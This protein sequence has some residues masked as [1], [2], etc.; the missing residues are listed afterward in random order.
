MNRTVVGHRE[1]ESNRSWWLA[2][3]AILVLAPVLGWAFVHFGGADSTVDKW[4]SQSAT[5][6]QSSAADADKDAKDKAESED[7][8][9][10]DSAAD[11]EN[12]D[13]EDSEPSQEKSEEASPSPSPTESETPAADKATEIRVLNGSRVNG[14]A[15]AKQQALAGAGFTNVIPGNYSGG[16]SPQASTIYYATEADEATAKEVGSSLGISN[17]QLSPQSVVGGKGIVVV[18]R[19]DIAG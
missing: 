14:L 2:A 11:A 10:D 8:A 7:E 16:A 9:K 15:T 17:I 13:A 3:L 5:A 12:K 1:P 19:A 18:L 4:P 6:Q